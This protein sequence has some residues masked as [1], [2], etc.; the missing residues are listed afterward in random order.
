MIFKQCNEVNSKYNYKIY[1]KLW[2]HKYV[3]TVLS[4]VSTA[5]K[6]ATKTYS[7]KIFINK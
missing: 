5:N 2:T 1:K 4:P 7:F 3:L 6:N